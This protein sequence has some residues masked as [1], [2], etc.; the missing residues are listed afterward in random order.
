LQQG[1]SGAP[2][3]VPHRGS[4]LPARLVLLELADDRLPRNE[5]FDDSDSLVLVVLD[6]RGE[7]GA[8]P[9]LPGHEG[10]ADVSG[11]VP[12]G[13]EPAAKLEIDRGGSDVGTDEAA[14]ALQIHASQR[15]ERAGD[16]Q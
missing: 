7:H 15:E 5:G 12:G 10:A 13:L 16:L 11:A 3:P 4:Y 1:N 2:L 14:G 9:Q 8:G 6:R